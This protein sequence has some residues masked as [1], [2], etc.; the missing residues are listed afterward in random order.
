MKPQDAQ[1]FTMKNGKPTFHKLKNFK[2]YIWVE[3]SS[4]VGR[5]SICRDKSIN[6]SELAPINQLLEAKLVVMKFGQAVKSRII[7]TVERTVC[8]DLSHTVQAG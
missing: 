1:S 4:Q 8:T 3:D 5:W 2:L 7:K 6:V